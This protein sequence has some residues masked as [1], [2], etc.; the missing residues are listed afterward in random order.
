MGST[1]L[2][3]ELSLSFPDSFEVMGDDELREG[4]LDDNPNRWGIWDRQRHVII[5]VYWHDSNALLARMVSTKGLAERAERLMAKSYAGHGFQ[6]GGFFEME[7]AGH[8]ARGFSYRYD[9][10]GVG[11]SAETVVLKHGKCCYTL[12]YYAREG[13]KPSDHEAFENVLESMRFV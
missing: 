13:G 5:V 4:Y 12:Y 7:V 9:L 1:V 6:L 3:D 11:Q 10:R 2:H 8:E